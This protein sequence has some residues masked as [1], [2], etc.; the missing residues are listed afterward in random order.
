MPYIKRL[1]QHRMSITGLLTL[2]E[3]PDLLECGLYVGKPPGETGAK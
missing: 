2:Q 1:T 3:C